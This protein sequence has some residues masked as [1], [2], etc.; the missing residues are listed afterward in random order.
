[1]RNV[2]SESWDTGPDPILKKMLD[3]NP[4]LMNTDPQPS[5]QIAVYLI[6]KSMKTRFLMK[7]YGD[8]G[9][10]FINLVKEGFLKNFSYNLLFLVVKTE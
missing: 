10:V 8:T 7:G 4:Y 1:L 6:E 3:P 9:Y 2:V 5:Q